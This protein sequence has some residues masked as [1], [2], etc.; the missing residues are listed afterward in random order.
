[1][2]INNFLNGLLA[3]HPNCECYNSDVYT[4]KG[5]RICK[6]CTLTIIGLI[7]SIILFYLWSL[8]QNLVLDYYPIIESILVL[9]TILNYLSSRSLIPILRKIGLGLAVGNIFTYYIHGTSLFFQIGSF[10]AFFAIYIVTYF[11]RQ[12]QSNIRLDS[13]P[14][15]HLE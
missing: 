13:C 10:S 12:R 15:L 9:P 5:V 1:M 11:L 4:I 8:Y 7:S 3:H 6:G 14:H 2:K